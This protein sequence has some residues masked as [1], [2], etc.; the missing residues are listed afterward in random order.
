MNLYYTAE[1]IYGKESENLKWKRIRKIHYIHVL[2][3]MYISESPCCIPETNTTYNQLYFNKKEE[4]E[5]EEIQY[6]RLHHSMEHPPERNCPGLGQRS[7]AGA[8][9]GKGY[10]GPCS[11]WATFSGLSNS[12][13]KRDQ[14]PE[15]SDLSGLVSLC[16]PHRSARPHSQEPWSGTCLA[17][18]SLGSS[19]TVW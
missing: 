12:A 9:G 1:G 7:P 11:G 3:Y 19:R 8:Q 18:A 16:L 2:L 10:P 6:C 17:C 15:Q 4:E 5:E 13:L 14:K